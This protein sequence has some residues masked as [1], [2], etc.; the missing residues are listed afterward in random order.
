MAALPLHG[1]SGAPI[2]QWRPAA[3]CATPVSG[4][5]DGSRRSSLSALQCRGA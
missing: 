4:P 3:A 5:D 1:R 2:R